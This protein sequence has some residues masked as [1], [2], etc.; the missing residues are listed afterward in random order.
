[1]SGFWLAVPVILH[2]LCRVG[3]LGAEVGQCVVKQV[4]Y[5]HLGHAEAVADLVPGEVAVEAEHQDALFPFGQFVQVARV[6]SMSM[7][8]A[9]AGSSSPTRSAS[10]AGSAPS[11]SGAS[12]GV[13]GE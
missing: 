5:V 3:D 11:D 2:V 9:T 8:W 4:G 6:A 1:M 7:T 12:G 10:M 13:G